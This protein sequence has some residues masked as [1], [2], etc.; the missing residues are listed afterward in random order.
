MGQ[1]KLADHDFDI[2]AE[3]VFFAEDFDDAAA[4]ILRGAGP[5]GDFHVHHHAFEILPAGVDCGLAADDAIMGFLLLLSGWFCRRNLYHR[6]HSGLRILHSWRDYDFLGH[7]FVE[8]LDVVVAMS[9]V[10]DA[11][12]GRMRAREGADDAAFGAAIAA[13]GGDF[14]EDTVAVHGGSDGVRRN[15]D[16]A[17]EV[18][19]KIRIERSG[20]GDDEAE[21]V[22]MHGQAADEKVA[23]HQGSGFRS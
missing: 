6:G 4:R 8:G 7:F 12:D 13:D 15:E 22:A 18:G 5:I 23:W 14:D 19:L 20:F 11:D 9:A 3:I 1:V 21:A 2:N 16:I 17:G 10:E